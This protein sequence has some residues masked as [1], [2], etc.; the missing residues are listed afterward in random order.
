MKNSDKP[1][2]SSIYQPGLNEQQEAV[3][4]AH[5]MHQMNLD[6][7]LKRYS[8][9]EYDQIALKMNAEAINTYL[10]PALLR[11]SEQF[12][13]KRAE[14]AQARA[15]KNYKEYGLSS[16][17]EISVAEII[18]EVLFDRQF[19][20]GPKSNCS[21]QVF[22]EKIRKRLAANKIIAM[23]IP[24][25]PY[26]SSSP[27]KTRGIMPD[28]S[29]INFLLGLTEIAR[30]IELIYQTNKPGPQA[31]AKFTVI[32]DGSRF[33]SFLNESIETIHTYQTQ[34]RWW[35]NKLNIANY[36]EIVD[37]QWLLKNHLPEEL[38][39]KKEE[40]KNHARQQY[41]QLML[42]L[43]DPYNTQKMIQAA[44]NKDPEPEA[45]N[46]EG[47]FIPLFKS[48]LYIVRYKTLTH[49]A[50]LHKKS[51][52]KLYTELTRHIFMPYTKLIDTDQE[53]MQSFIENPAYPTPP[54]HKKRLEYLRQSMLHEAWHAAIDYIAEIRS[55]RDLPKEPITASLPEHIRWTIHAKAGQLAI[56]TTTASGDP[57]QAW[58]GTGVFKLTK[59]NKIKI[60]TLPVLSLEGTQ[61]IPVSIS[62]G[63]QGL[64][65]KDQPLFYVHPELQFTNSTELLNKIAAN[66]T[67]SRKL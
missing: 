66:L 24:A 16:I 44:I 7:Q 37:Y 11:A 52:T 18:T 38:Y 60:Y 58:H 32:S 55:D 33:N 40:I 57:I 51:Y 23:A 4:S 59:N 20:K 14:A 3:I 27:L 26:K 65:L 8:D 5:F 10:L 31:S 63:E 61:A 19:L 39:I 30:T 49:Y 47:R 67:R 41:A 12:I 21:K 22:V 54:P 45:V 1:V 9:E 42:P 29:E 28:L 25:L 15:L 56:L 36:I 53:H 64:M 17:A 6:T 34:L 35:I 13:L 2:Q 46:P 50:E 43:F 62:N 48:L